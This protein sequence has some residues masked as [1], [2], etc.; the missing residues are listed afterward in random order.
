MS[1]HA[2]TSHSLLSVSRYL[3]LTLPVP[4]CEWAADRGTLPRHAAVSPLAELSLL[5]FF[6]L[7]S[8]AQLT[9]SLLA[10][11]TKTLSVCQPSIWPPHA[12]TALAQTVLWVWPGSLPQPARGHQVDTRRCG[13]QSSHRPTKITLATRRAKPRATQS[14]TH[15]GCV[16]S[17]RR[18]L[19]HH[20]QTERSN[21]PVWKSLIGH[22][23]AWRT[24]ANI[25][26]NVGE[27]L[28]EEHF[29]GEHFGNHNVDV[30]RDHCP[31]HHLRRPHPHLYPPVSVEHHMC[32][33]RRSDVGKEAAT[34]GLV[35]AEYT[36]KRRSHATVP[37]TINATWN[38]RDCGCR[39]CGE[40]VNARRRRRQP[41]QQPP[42]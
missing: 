32:R 35:P 1:T 8:L 28:G 31:P 17:P 26:A 23:L 36:A 30:R 16:P 14:H 19:V 11:H 33:P 12:L 2:H 37:S 38:V 9:Y 3:T 34:C 20:T 24:L 5:L 7:R 25:W 29:A 18:R 27:H 13:F 39:G 42:Q 15:V 41:W 21:P 10:L 6:G 4:A 22:W 40:I